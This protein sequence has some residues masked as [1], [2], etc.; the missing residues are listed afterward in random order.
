MGVK[1]NLQIN[2]A[3]Y[4]IEILHP[5]KDI[6]VGEGELGR[7]VVTDI[8][9]HYENEIPQLASGKRRL[10]INNFTAENKKGIKQF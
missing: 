4:F 9:I 6:P 5:D 8:R 2:W 3:S 7:V 10:I 1:D